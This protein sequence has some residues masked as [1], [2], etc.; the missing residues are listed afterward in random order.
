MQPQDGAARAYV[1]RQFTCL[2]PVSTGE[3]LE[4][5]LQEGVHER[6]G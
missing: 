6:S 3:A 4:E 5:E 1:C 2:P